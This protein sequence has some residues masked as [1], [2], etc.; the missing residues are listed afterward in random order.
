[1]QGLFVGL[2]GSAAA[3]TLEGIRTREMRARRDGGRCIVDAVV[4]A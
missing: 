2:G 3:E 1:V 4:V